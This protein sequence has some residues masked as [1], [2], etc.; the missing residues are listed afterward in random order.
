MTPRLLAAA[1]LLAGAST[2]CASDVKGARQF[3]RQID[4]NGDRSL[5][6]S[7]IQAARAALFDRL[8]TRR[9]GTLDAAALERAMAKALKERPQLVH[10]GGFGSR[11]PQIDGNGDGRITRA[12]FAAFVPGRLRAADRNGDGALSPREL[13]ALKP[14]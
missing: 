10:A 13:R 4:A 6:F 11:A 14:R 1:L 2:A 3:F 9:E 12:E 5:Q 8:D 7:E